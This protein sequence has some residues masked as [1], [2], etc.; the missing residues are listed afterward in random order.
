[1]VIAGAACMR[2]L[3]ASADN[4]ANQPDD[5]VV[6]HSPL[7]ATQTVDMFL[8]YSPECR[9]CAALIDKTIFAVAERHA[10]IVRLH[11]RDIMDRNGF[12]LLMDEL[13]ERNI[14]LK[15]FP[16][17][18]MR[19][20]V[21][22]GEAEIGEGLPSLVESELQDREKPA[23]EP[24]PGFHTALLAPAPV[25]L[26]GLIDGINPCAFTT[27]IFLLSSLA[28]GKKGRR[29]MLVTGI[30]FTFSVFITYTAIGIGALSL[31]RTASLFPLLSSI[32][33]YAMA[34]VL[35]TFSLLSFVDAVRIRSARS[36]EALLQLSNGTKRRIHRVIRNQRH[37][38]SIVAG[39]MLLGVL[40]TTFEL[41]CTGQIYLPSIVYLSRVEK[42]LRSYLL[43][44]LYNIA[45]VLPLVAVFLT[46]YYGMSVKTLTR[47]FQQ[48][49][50]TTKILTG[51]LFLILAGLL[52]LL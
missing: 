51:A 26:A 35:V 43:L 20:G 32:R 17:L 6:I 22:Q 16:V 11:K 41:G 19:L 24:S 15:A 28:L 33:R 10:V 9:S 39:S 50:G 1:M 31:V 13:S 30:A 25:F 38:G 29:E 5:T 12:E 34:T 4:G 2:L 37:S 45:F 14:P 49:L 18:M 46:A 48:H 47:L 36:G 44:I 27:I 23:N 42:S 21:L 3:A 52:I 8:Y 7:G 40:V